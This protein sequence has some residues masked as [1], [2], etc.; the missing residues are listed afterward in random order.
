MGYTARG[1]DEIRIQPIVVYKAWDIQVRV[2]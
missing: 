2:S 1:I